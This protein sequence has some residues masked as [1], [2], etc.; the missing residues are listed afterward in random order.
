MHAEQPQL[1]EADTRQLVA[2]VVCHA[3]RVQ[4]LPSMVIRSISLFKML[5]HS[6][7]LP[8]RHFQDPFVLVKVKE[9]TGEGLLVYSGVAIEEVWEDL[10]DMAK[11]L[12]HGVYMRTR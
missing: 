12:G 7:N 3:T 11:S 10:P 2:S 1:H 6:L 4:R 9:D 8:S 5:H